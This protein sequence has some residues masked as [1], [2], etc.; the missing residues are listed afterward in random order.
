MELWVHLCRAA[1]KEA[2]VP[3]WAR[4]RGGGVE[5]CGE[6][7]RELRVVWFVVL[8]CTGPSI[9]LHAPRDSG[10]NLN[11]KVAAVR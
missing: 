5:G 11:P 1:V 9:R 10:Y 7:E 8:P 3:R 6:R 4:F 2:A